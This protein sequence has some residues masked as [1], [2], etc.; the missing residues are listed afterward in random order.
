MDMVHNSYL[1]ADCYLIVMKYFS[2]QCGEFT[3]ILNIK[4]Y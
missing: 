2:M 3:E 1:I 4:E